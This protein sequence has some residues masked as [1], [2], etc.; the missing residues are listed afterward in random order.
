MSFNCLLASTIRIIVPLMTSFFF[1]W[2]LLKFP[3][4]FSLEQLIM[5]FLGVFSLYLS[6]LGFTELL[7]S[8]VMSFISFGKSRDII[9]LN[10]PSLHSF[11][12]LPE[13]QNTG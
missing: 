5:M 6:Y 1:L 11:F 13:L 4:I 12:P 3:F 7:V 10:I 9:S 2:L 8:V